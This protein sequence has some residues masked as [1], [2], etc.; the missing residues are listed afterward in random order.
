MKTNKKYKTFEDY[1]KSYYPKSRKS[2]LKE[3][4]DPYEYG[5][6]LANSSAR[7]IKKILSS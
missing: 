6:E 1:H 4:D 3:I 2:K 7:K 5:I